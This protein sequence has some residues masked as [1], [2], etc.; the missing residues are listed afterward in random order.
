MTGEQQQAKPAKRLTLI[1]G[2]ARSGKSSFA[3]QLAEARQ[4]DVLFVAT[5][6][7]GDADMAARIAKHQAERPRHWQT[8]E[9]PRRVAHVLAQAEPAPVVLLDCVTL[10]VTNLLLSEGATWDSAAQELDA[11]LAWYRSQPGDVPLE[12]IIVTNEVGLGIVP[13]D[14]LSRTFRDWLGLF[15]Q[16][17]AAEADHVYLLV[18]GLPIDIKMYGFTRSD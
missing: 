3:Q 1:T 18:A 8:L 16:R 10:W 13:V 15:N 5:A 2:G 4:T 17:L 6:E 11:L 12:V 7:A 14:A 9:A